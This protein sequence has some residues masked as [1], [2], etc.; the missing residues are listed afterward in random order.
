MTDFQSIFFFSF[1]LKR[2]RIQLLTTREVE[3]LIKTIFRETLLGPTHIDP[4]LRYSETIPEEAYP[5][6]EKEMSFFRVNPFDKTPL[7]VETLLEFVYFDNVRR[8]FFLSHNLLSLNQRR[9]LLLL[10]NLVL[11][12]LLLFILLSLS[13]LLRYLECM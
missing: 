3:P 9:L 11:L 5:D 8:Y 1:F 2:R 13:Y 10:I 7:T 12:R 6:L 4:P